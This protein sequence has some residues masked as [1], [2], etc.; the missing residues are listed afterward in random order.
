MKREALAVVIAARAATILSKSEKS[1]KLSS[2]FV[3]GKINELFL[4]KKNEEQQST[5]RKDEWKNVEI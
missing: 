2:P 5:K 1:L 3:G 4:K